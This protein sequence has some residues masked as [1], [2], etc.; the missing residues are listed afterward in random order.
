M[1]L[2]EALGYFLYALNASFPS[3]MTIFFEHK[4]SYSAHALCSDHSYA[5]RSL[6]AVYTRH[7]FCSLHHVGESHQLLLHYDSTVF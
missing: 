2:K 5:G 4:Y 7:G 6:S 3:H 1:C